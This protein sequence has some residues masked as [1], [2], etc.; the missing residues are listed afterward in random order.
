MLKERRGGLMLYLANLPPQIGALHQ[1]GSNSIVL[2]R[3][4]LKAIESLAKS[5][6]ELNSFIY[7]ILLHEYLH[8]LGYIDE[9]ET[10]I[11]TVKITR[12]VFGDFHPATKMAKNPMAY[13][14][15]IQHQLNKLPLKEGKPE[16]VKDFDRSSQKYFI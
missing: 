2:N 9:Q 3:L 13:Y 7:T 8:S 4:V 6:R 16:I 5:R 10:R 12:E 14:P 1:V 15:E 11:L